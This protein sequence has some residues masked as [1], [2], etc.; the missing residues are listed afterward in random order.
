MLETVDWI[1]FSFSKLFFKYVHTLLFILPTNKQK[2]NSRMIIF[3][4]KTLFAKNAVKKISD[5]C[6]FIYICCKFL[7][8]LFHL[9]FLLLS[10]LRAARAWRAY[11]I[12]PERL[13]YITHL[14]V[15]PFVLLQQCTTC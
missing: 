15:S 10:T 3:I 6:H 13:A 14:T 2:T 5:G 4:V 7:P 1:N 9:S 8:S 12:K 11:T